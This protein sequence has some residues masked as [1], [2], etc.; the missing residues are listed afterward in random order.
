MFLECPL[1]SYY[2]I[3]K[4]HLLSLFLLKLFNNFRKLLLGPKR[5]LSSLEVYFRKFLKFLEYLKHPISNRYHNKNYR[6][7]LK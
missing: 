7:E 1:F 3:P 2:R 5:M 4:L 6:H